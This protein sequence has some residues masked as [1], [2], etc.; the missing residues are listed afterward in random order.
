MKLC[1]IVCMALS[2]ASAVVL[3]EAEGTL[4]ERA[5]PS[6]AGDFVCGSAPSAGIR[7][8]APFA[9]GMVLQS[10]MK[11]PVWGSATPGATVTVS[12]AGQSKAATAGA[13]GAWRVDL[14]PL[15]SSRVGRDMT[16]RAKQPDSQTILHDV[17]VGE[18][19]YV[20]GQSNME[21]PMWEVSP[22]FRDRNGA[23]VA[24]MTDK[25]LV[26][27]C[28]ASNYRASKT[29]Q[30]SASYPVKW[31]KFDRK[32]LGSG[33]SF[34]AVGAYFALELYSALEIPIGIVGSY[35]GGT[36][37]EP[38]IPAEGFASVGLDPSKCVPNQEEIQQ[39]CV[40]WNEMVNPM[41]PMAL[42]GFIWYQG[43]SNV[44]H[45]EL[46]CERM[47]ALYNGWAE[48][49]ENRSLKLYFV[50][51]APWYSGG[52]PEFQQAQAKFETEEPN[53]G[54]AIINDLGNLN[55]I[56]PNEKATVAKR[57]A[58]HALKRDYG[59]GSIRDDSPTLKSWEQ[60]PD[61]IVLTFDN[62][63]DFYIYNPEYCSPSNGFEICGADGI[64]KPAQIMNFKKQIRHGQL[65]FLGD[66]DGNRIVLSTKDI[67]SPKGIRYLFSHPWY[68]SIY[69]EVNLPLGAFAVDLQK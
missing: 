3:A 43:C 41:V 61:R 14:D 15:K 21:C 63:D 50:Q 47:H 10:G 1:S 53:S 37:I 60:K 55:D 32:S 35:Y 17:L 58:V 67:G 59:F 54:M 30:T 68:G 4:R 57:L 40:L 23:L 44:A 22:R 51:L 69:N 27:M 33:H 34:S 28:Y 46:Y 12:F 52:H 19:W 64:W 56:H 29:P 49:F 24:Q 8:G 65:R 6:G 20:S 16:V 11:V 42:R 36:C 48:K 18:V 26:R 5:L 38:W 2:L 9:D 66:I 62:V 7:L 25:P 13:S 31:E 45:P 39:P